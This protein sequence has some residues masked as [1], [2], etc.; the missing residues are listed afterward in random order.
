[1]KSTE[2]AVACCKGT[3]LGVCHEEG[4]SAR[5]SFFYL[6]VYNKRYF[7]EITIASQPQN[8]LSYNFGTSL[9]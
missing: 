1:M 3:C 2:T 7:L 5:K 6:P 4:N 9:I 8:Q